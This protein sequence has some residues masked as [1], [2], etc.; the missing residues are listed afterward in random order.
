VTAARAAKVAAIAGAET[1][2]PVEKAGLVA[3]K[4]LLGAS[5]RTLSL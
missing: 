3:S 1:E 2:A 4:H 5:R